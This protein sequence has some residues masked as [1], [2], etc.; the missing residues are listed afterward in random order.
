MPGDFGRCSPMARRR[1]D[2]GKNGPVNLSVDD[3]EELLA[4]GARRPVDDEADEGALTQLDHARQTAAALRLEAP[5][6]DELVVAGLVHDIGHLLVGVRDAEHATAGAAAVRE[7]LGERVAGL[8]GRHVEAK[9]YL[10]GGESSY[11]GRLSAESVTSLV[12][13]GGPMAPAERAAFEADPGAADAIVL[14]R[15]DEAAKVD[16]LVVEGLGEWMEVVR[17]VHAHAG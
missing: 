11:G 13:Q 2:E 10:V 15:A 4:T 12:A 14:R 7:A 9:R 8:V 16:G 3:I 17:R 6:D 1:A 5:H